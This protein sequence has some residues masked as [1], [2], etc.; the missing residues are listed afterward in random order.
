MTE[1]ISLAIIGGSGL[2]NMSGL[3]DSIEYNIETPFGKPSAPIVVGTLEGKRIAFLARHGI[4]HH[5]MPTEC[6]LPSQHLCV[7]KA[8][9]WNG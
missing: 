5:I 4:G 2:Y 8:W 9:E 3:T 7:E 1:N 6:S